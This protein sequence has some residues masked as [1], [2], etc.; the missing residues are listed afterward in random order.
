MNSPG[1]RRE[2]DQSERSA[3]E[4]NPQASS[5]GSNDPT[6]ALGR[7]RKFWTE[8]MAMWVLVSVGASF[9]PPALTFLSLSTRG[10]LTSLAD[11]IGHG[12]LLS[13]TS[14][15]SV[16]AACAL[17]VSRA[18]SIRKLEVGIAT[19]LILMGTSQFQADVAAAVRSAIHID[20][21]VVV[22]ASLFLH[23]CAITIG[24][25]CVWLADEP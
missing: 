13:M 8:R 6:Q 4:K 1:N 7:T 11:V 20:S 25:R 18:P 23:A 3:S 5:S 22:N 2:L 12:E 16:V 15:L 14:G 21:A 24:S 9:M 19:L 17:F 10:A